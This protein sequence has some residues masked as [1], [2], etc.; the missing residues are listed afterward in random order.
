MKKIIPVIF[1][2]TLLWGCVKSATDMNVL[3]GNYRTDDIATIGPVT[4]YTKNNVTTDAV[5][6]SKYINA[7]KSKPLFD[8]T[9]KNEPF[10]LYS[11]SIEA[12]NPNKIN[13]KAL[14][15]ATGVTTSFIGNVTNLTST[16]LTVQ[17]KTDTLYSY[18][19][20][21]YNAYSTYSI[22]KYNY[23]EVISTSPSAGISRVALKKGIT[24][25]KKGSDFY[26]PLITYYQVSRTPNSYSY[27]STSSINNV[28]VDNINSLIGA[29]DTIVVQQRLIKLIR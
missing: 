11:I 22:Q 21:S 27:F 16:D 5:S 6:I 25:V 10:N 13:V 2:A 4:M 23:Y 24:L 3:I 8:F 19:I 7:A 9:N 17:G 26:L 20:P 28:L 18:Q 15:Y 29:K 12:K 1:I 14:T